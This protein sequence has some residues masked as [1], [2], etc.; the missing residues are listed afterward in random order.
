MDRNPFERLIGRLHCV[1]F[2][3]VNVTSKLFL[4]LI[5]IINST[6]FEIFKHQISGI[7][8]WIYDEVIQVQT[9]H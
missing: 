3:R 7:K 4:L 8:R 2:Q 1:S 6:E 5:F 9:Q